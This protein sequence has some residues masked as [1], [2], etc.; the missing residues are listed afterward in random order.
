MKQ[1]TS[2]SMIK[3]DL[4]LLALVLVFALA[5]WIY[6]DG[7]GLV[8]FAALGLA[9]LVQLVRVASARGRRDTLSKLWN[10]LKDAFW[11]IG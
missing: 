5:S 10:A 11:G 9:A 6:R 1:A 8:V 3:T 7:L 4:S 2:T